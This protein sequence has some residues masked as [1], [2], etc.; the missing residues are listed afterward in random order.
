MVTLPTTSSARLVGHGCG[1]TSGAT[2][3]ASSAPA[4]VPTIRSTP[5][6]KLLATW[7]R[8]TM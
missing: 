6:V 2:S 5:R 8:I 7:E 4:P 1:K 3:K